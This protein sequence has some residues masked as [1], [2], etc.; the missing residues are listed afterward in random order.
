M[1]LKIAIKS[2]DGGK[3]EGKS[4]DNFYNNLYHETQ[5]FFHFYSL[6]KK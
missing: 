2:G 4:D 6:G 3:T 5:I 1:I